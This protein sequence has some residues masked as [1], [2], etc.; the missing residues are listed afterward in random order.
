MLCVS[1]QRNLQTRQNDRQDRVQGCEIQLSHST[2]FTYHG[3]EPYTKVIR[4]DCVKL[5]VCRDVL[6]LK[7]ACE[8]FL[9]SIGRAKFA[10]PNNVSPIKFV[11]IVFEEKAINC[12]R[13]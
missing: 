7:V 4:F 9:I 6:F 13:N 5:C 10:D 11:I 3:G 8:H 1:E 2:R 12:G